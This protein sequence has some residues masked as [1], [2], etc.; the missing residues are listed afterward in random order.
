[1]SWLAQGFALRGVLPPGA[2]A[3]PLAAWVG[4]LEHQSCREWVILLDDLPFPH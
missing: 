1:M 3:R 2:G 4:G